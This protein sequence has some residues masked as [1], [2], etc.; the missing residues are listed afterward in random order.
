[1]RLHLKFLQIY[2]VSNPILLSIVFLI[3]NYWLIN[4]QSL[5]DYTFF[6]VKNIEA[7]SS[8]TIRGW[9]DAPKPFKALKK[10]SKTLAYFLD[11][12]NSKYKFIDELIKEKELPTQFG[13][14]PIV[15]SGYQSL[16]KSKSGGSGIWSMN[17]IIGLHHGLLMN[18]DIDERYSDNY[19]TIAA[20]KELNRLMHLYKDPNWTILA[21]MSSV[22][23]VRDIKNKTGSNS[24][25]EAMSVIDK[26]YLD[27]INF[28]YFLESLAVENTPIENKELKIEKAEFEFDYTLSFDAIYSFTAIDFKSFKKDNPILINNLI[29]SNYK[30]SFTKEEGEK[31]ISAQEAISQF[32]DSMVNNLFFEQDSLIRR[33]HKVVS[34]DVL[35][36]IAEKYGVSIKQIMSWNK[37]NNTMI[38]IDQKLNIFS[39]DLT[40]FDKFDHYDLYD[41]KTFWQIAENLSTHTI[42]DILKYNKYESLK[43][44]KKLRIIKK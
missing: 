1:M 26:N 42:L 33:V 32:Q 6:D 25:D 8:K 22:N 40:A 3:S 5:N 20:I 39:N 15:L 12:K 41:E 11:Q 13:F 14:L 37:L 34:G 10:E 4:A 2:N 16:H 27:K 30:V 29:P 28:L 7:S 9:K 31:L 18:R 38:Y 35:G 19:S 44:N 23:Y 43:T 36:L 21:F 17:Y 24:W